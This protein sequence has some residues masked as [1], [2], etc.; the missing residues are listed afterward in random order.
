[1]R[2]IRAGRTHKHLLRRRGILNEAGRLGDATEMKNLG[3]IRMVGDASTLWI[4]HSA[5]RRS[6]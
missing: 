2:V 5:A 3:E 1:M 4:L 6:E